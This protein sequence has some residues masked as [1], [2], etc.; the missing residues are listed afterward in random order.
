MSVLEIIGGVFLIAAGLAIIFFVS[1]Q[2]E[3]SDGL[4][5]VIMGNDNTVYKGKAR[6]NEEKLATVTKYCAIVFFVL[7]LLLNIFVLVAR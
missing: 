3:K 5:G 6:S 1:L 2:T 7:G 4:S